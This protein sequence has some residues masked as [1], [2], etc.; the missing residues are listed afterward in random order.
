MHKGTQ[1]VME[2]NQDPPE[3]S[4]RPAVDVLFR[5][6]ARVYGPG[7]LA[8]VMTGMGSDGARG[9]EVIHDAGGEVLV[10]DESSS[11][12][13]G[14]PGAVVGAGAAD[15]ICP[16]PEISLEVVRRVAAGRTHGLH[17]ATAQE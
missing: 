17:A 4:C 6:I 14:M 7:A 9:A 10:Q 8:L 15:K 16:L 5:S 13:W 3:N 2:L 11:V 12:V 1:V